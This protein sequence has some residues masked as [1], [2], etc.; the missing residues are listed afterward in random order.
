MTR[1]SEKRGSLFLKYGLLIL[2]KTLMRMCLVSNETLKEILFWH[3]NNWKIVDCAGHVR[4][5]SPIQHSLHYLS[6]MYRDKCFSGLI[7][8]VE[9]EA[10]ILH[11][12]DNFSSMLMTKILLVRQPQPDGKLV[13]Q[14]YDG[15]HRIAYFSFYG[16]KRIPYHYLEIADSEHEL[17][18]L[19]P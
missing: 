6:L 2:R 3:A 9:P 8:D 4:Y 18:H 13:Y 19:L 11:L 7:E 17:Y 5:A 14:I 16:L 10:R 1:D 15:C 12:D